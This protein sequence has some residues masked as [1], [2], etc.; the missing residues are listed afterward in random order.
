MAQKYSAAALPVRRSHSRTEM[1]RPKRNVGGP[2]RIARG[3][4]SIWLLVVAAAAYWDDAHER[5]AITGIAGL[6]LLFNVVT[7]FCGGNFLLGVDTA[8]GACDR[9]AN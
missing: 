1:K 3:V 7:G 6:G 9:G 4:L 5:A 8:D 2:D